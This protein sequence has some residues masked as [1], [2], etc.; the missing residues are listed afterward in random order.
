VSPTDN[1]VPILFTVDLE[2]LRDWN[3]N[4]WAIDDHIPYIYTMLQDFDLVSRF[5]I[6]LPKLVGFCE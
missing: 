3:I 1:Q 4:V 5:K 6:E 2:E